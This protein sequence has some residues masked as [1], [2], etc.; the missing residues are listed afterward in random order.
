MEGA[1]VRLAD[2]ERATTSGADGG[3]VLE[4]LPSGQHIV[5]IRRFGYL[6]AVR[7]IR[8]D[9]AGTVRLDAAL[10]PSPLALDEV[11]VTA[12]GERRR[13]EL[14]HVVERI[15]SEEAR[16]PGVL[17]FTDLLTARVPGVQVLDN[18]GTIGL[19]SRVRIRGSN[20]M[21]LSNEPIVYV[22]GVRI[23]NRRGGFFILFIGGHRPSRLDDLDLQDIQSVEIAK[24]PAA[25]ALYGTEAA[26]GVI[27]VRTRRGRSGGPRWRIHAEGGLLTDPV[28]YPANFGAVDEAGSPCP[29]FQVAAGACRQE[30][31]RSYTV[32]E[33]PDAT[34][35]RGGERAE[36]GLG[37]SG[38]GDVLG[39][40]L[41]GGAERERGVLGVPERARSSGERLPGGLDPDYR[42]E[43]LDRVSGRAN[44]D[45]RPDPRLEVGT[46]LAF[47]GS[48]LSMP[49]NDTHPLGV[50]PSGLLGF[51]TP[52]TNGGW[53]VLRPEESYLGNQ[54]HRNDRLLGAL[55]A[56]WR[57]SE[58]LSLR[59]AYG[60]DLSSR[61][62]IEFWPRGTAISAGYRE[63]DRIEIRNQTADASASLDLDLSPTLRSTT[64]A[65]IQYFR[66]FVEGTIAVG[67]DLAPGSGS[68]SGAAETSSSEFSA[69]TRSLGLLLQER[70][71]LRDR[72][73]LTASVRGDDN[74]TFGSS[75]DPVLYPKLG[76]SWVVSAEEWFPAE[77]PVDEL[78]VRAAWGTS[79]LEPGAAPPVPSFGS[80]PVVLDGEEVIGVRRSDLGNP[81]LEPERVT[82]IE[83]G[84]DAE[85]LGRRVAVSLTAYHKR[86]SDALVFRPVAPSVGVP[87]GR[88]QNI[89][90][91]RNRGIEASVEGSV[92][93]RPDI[94][95]RLRLAGSVNGNRLLELAPGVDPI[96]LFGGPRHQPG[97][98]LGGFWARPLLEFGDVDGD[99]LIDAEEISV[100][101]TAVFLGT[102]VPSRELSVDSEVRLGEHVVV[103]ALLD[104]R[105]GHV[106]ANHTEWLRC[107]NVGVC[108]GLHDPAA[109]HFEQARALAATEHPAATLAGYVENAAFWAL[110]EVSVEFTVPRDLVRRAGLSDA[111]LTLAGRNLAT[112]SGYGGIDPEVSWAAGSFAA[113]E[114]F[115]MPVPRSWTAR[116]AVAF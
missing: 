110:R 80:L 54:L 73:F 38:G 10:S 1:T 11:V 26:N 22:D 6:T 39:Y 40:Y 68:I 58:T 18:S 44:L 104:H 64:T 8:I 65:G 103:G 78:R 12:T 37:V 61:N 13:R 46:S 48:D 51:P 45:L 92:L 4:G 98:P 88:L 52:E 34:P 72:L 53:R 100:G 59:A 84:V 102:P 35:I 85:L 91:V 28:T 87:G 21:S 9:A 7:S 96:F 33:D 93:E 15:G 17:D 108:R 77:G 3:Y 81:E 95:W 63:S 42:P 29:L 82:E 14:G 24:G 57:P 109:S 112:W 76:A 111:T 49:M 23:D 66:S 20:S 113:V 94:E 36:I 99:G 32:L 90:S 105:G 115:T 55:R 67:T 86:S 101:D 16:R 106:H 43:R 2:T 70:I 74:S 27:R 50:L 69:E 47:W 62:S 116:L 79:G 97:Y 56:R 71:G 31:L 89:G 30:R 83:A 25:T 107:R 75:V 60:V 114:R 19:E 5:R 41:H